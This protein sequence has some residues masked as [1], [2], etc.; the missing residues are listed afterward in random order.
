MTSVTAAIPV[1]VAASLHEDGHV[2]YIAR[3]RG[4]VESLAAA[5]VVLGVASDV[6]SL[7]LSRDAIA[8]VLQPARWRSTRAPTSELTLRIDDSVDI[9]IEVDAENT[10]ELLR[11][12]SEIAAILHRNG[13]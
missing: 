8:E 2:A 7:T 13:S 11:I 3:D 10:G 1:A 5:I 9:R 12:A 4:D 6:V